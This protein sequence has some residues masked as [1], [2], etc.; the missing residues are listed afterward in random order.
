[1]VS[2]RWSRTYMRL[3]RSFGEDGNR[4]LSRRIGSVIVDPNLNKVLSLGM[5]GPARGVPVPDSREYLEKV[6]WPQA[7]HGM[8]EAAR[9]GLGLSDHACPDAVLGKADGCG[10]CPRRLFGLASGERRDLC[11]CT[12]SER[13]AIYNAACDLNGAWLF[14]WADVMPCWECSTAIVQ[15]GIKKVFCV[16]SPAYQGGSANFILEKGGVAMTARPAS[17]WEA[18][19]D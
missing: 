15:V 19:D 6:A 9:R 17:Y 13:N 14:L 18:K 1:M 5:N 7:D 4:C 16:E 8:R 3:A 2:E 12:C 11:P 10:Q